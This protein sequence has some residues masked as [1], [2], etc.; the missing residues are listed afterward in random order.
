MHIPSVE[1]SQRLLVLQ[2]FLY[3][4]IQRTAAEIEEGNVRTEEQR[5]FRLTQGVTKGLKS[6]VPPR[7]P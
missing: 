7:Q 6:A 4:F 3:P 2:S 5:D 1:D